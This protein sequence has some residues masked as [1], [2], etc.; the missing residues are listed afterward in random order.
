MSWL[1]D[2]QEKV[3]AEMAEAEALGSMS[4]EGNEYCTNN[5]DCNS[6]LMCN[7]GFCSTCLDDGTGCSME[8]I[9]KPVTC[10]ETQAPGPTHCFSMNDLDTA[11]R[12]KLN[13]ARAVCVIDVMDC[14]I[15]ME[16][17]EE[18]FSNL[19]I[20]DESGGNT[21]FDNPEGNSFFCG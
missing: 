8:Q 16:G 1:R 9:C 3:A 21:V 10:G 2:K 5:D 13:D 15:S 17:S 4:D 7:N 14:E 18:D 6:E 12:V 19:Q 11:C 20:T